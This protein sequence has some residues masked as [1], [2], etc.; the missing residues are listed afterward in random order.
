MN[1]EE[2]KEIIKQAIANE[3]EAKKVLRRCIQNAPGP[4][5]QIALRLPCRGRKETSRYPDENL[6][7]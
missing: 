1:Q 7:Q 5:S 4:A 6:Q 3:V 2:Y